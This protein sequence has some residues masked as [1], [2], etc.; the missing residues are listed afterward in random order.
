MAGKNFH[1]VTMFPAYQSLYENLKTMGCNLSYWMAKCENGWKFKL[2]DLRKVIKPETRLLVVNFPHNPTGY[3]PEEKEWCELL[4]LCKANNIYL[5][6]DEMYRSISF[7]LHQINF[8]I[9]SV[10]I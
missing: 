7:V 9:N 8:Q 2:D 6:S 10:T 1:A 5:F 3:V 4:E